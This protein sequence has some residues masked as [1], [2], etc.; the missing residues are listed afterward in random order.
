[1]IRKIT[2]R[3]VY[4]LIINTRYLIYKILSTN[5]V[6]GKA[7]SKYPILFKG[8][9]KITIADY[10]QFGVHSSPFYLNTYGYIEARTEDSS[11]SIGSNVWLNNNFSLIA[12]KAKIIIRDKVLAGCN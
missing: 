12:G 10:T 5:H 4:T 11:V 3:V 7:R 8:K 6:Y 2:R 9:G 1:M